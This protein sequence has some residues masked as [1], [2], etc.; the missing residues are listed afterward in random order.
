MYAEFR[1]VNAADKESIN[2]DIVFEIELVKQVE[3]TV[4]Y[5]LMLVDQWRQAHGDG[6]DRQVEAT[7]AI[8]RAI[9]AS[10]T[11][12]NKKDLILAFVDEVSASGDVD[13]QWR[14]FVEQAP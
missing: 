6:D 10:P 12:R 11:L 14:A 9:D 2:D 13:E 3:I 8:A 4:D 7:A 1:R 5:I